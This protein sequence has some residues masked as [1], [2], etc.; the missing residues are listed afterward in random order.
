VWPTDSCRTRVRPRVRVRIV[1]R[2]GY[3]TFLPIVPE[4]FRTSPVSLV[5]E[6]SIFPLLISKNCHL[7]SSQIKLVK[8]CELCAILNALRFCN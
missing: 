5:S 7:K 2:T 4:T 6:Q 1:F 8:Y 3:E